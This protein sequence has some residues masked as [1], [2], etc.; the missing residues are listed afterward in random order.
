MELK[1]RVLLLD[2]W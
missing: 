1:E 2:T